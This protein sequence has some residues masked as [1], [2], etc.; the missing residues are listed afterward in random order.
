MLESREKEKEDSDERYA[1]QWG[2]WVLAF[3]RRR[4]ARPARLVSCVGSTG[5]RNKHSTVS[6]ESTVG[7]RRARPGG[8]RIWRRKTRGSRGSWRSVML[9]STSLWWY[10][11]TE[12]IKRLSGQAQ[13]VDFADL[14]YESRLA[15][16]LFTLEDSFNS[17]C[18]DGLMHST[19][20]IVTIK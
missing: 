2:E 16:V 18:F 7:F 19:I 11:L 13:D 20:L 8:W 6:V 3:W 10:R 1:V 14:R 4:I 12:K 9:K 15:I 5:F 17:E